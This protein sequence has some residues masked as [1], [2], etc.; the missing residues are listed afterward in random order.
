MYKVLK[1]VICTVALETSLRKKMSTQRAYGRWTQEFETTHPT[2]SHFL[3]VLPW[4]CISLR[5]VIVTFSRVQ[6]LFVTIECVLLTSHILPWLL[7]I[8]LG[9][10]IRLMSLKLLLLPF[11]LVDGIA[12]MLADRLIASNTL[13]YVYP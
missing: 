8:S 11:S 5:K 3:Y 1:E 7:A 9:G 4:I 10:T 2:L 6:P 12:T 13:N